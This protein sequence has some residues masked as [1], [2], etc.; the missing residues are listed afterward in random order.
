VPENHQNGGM[1]RE[2]KGKGEGKEGLLKKGFWGWL[3]KEKVVVVV[4]VE[5]RE[6]GKGESV[7]EVEMLE[8]V[9]VVA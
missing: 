4:G 3:R 2:E 1:E 7:V 6:G 9:E 8:C 5:K